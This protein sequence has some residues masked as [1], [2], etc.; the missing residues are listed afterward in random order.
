MDRKKEGFR[1]VSGVYSLGTGFPI[2]DIF[3]KVVLSTQFMIHNEKKHQS[4]KHL[5][6]VF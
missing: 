2:T 4:V 1:Q 6:S 3:T 5:I